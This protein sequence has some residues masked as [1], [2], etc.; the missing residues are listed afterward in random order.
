MESPALEMLK[1]AK[2]RSVRV[3]TLN[4]KVYRGVL[5][6]F[7]MHV[8]IHMRNGYVKADDGDELYVGEVLI[9][10]G[11]VACVDIV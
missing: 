5:E 6:D 2:N 4:S 7:D 11:T 9:N 10:G 1:K 3:V 8:N